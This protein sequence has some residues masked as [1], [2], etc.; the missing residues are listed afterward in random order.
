VTDFSM[1]E[2][3]CCGWEESVS[4]TFSRGISPNHAHTFCRDRPPVDR[5]EPPLPLCMEPSSEGAGMD[6]TGCWEPFILS[7]VTSRRE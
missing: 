6:A 3:C 2:S 4:Y 1:V 7:T 5:P